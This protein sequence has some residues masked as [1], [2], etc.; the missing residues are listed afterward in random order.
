MVIFQ[1]VAVGIVATLLTLIM[2]KQSP[3]FGLYISLATGVIIFFMIIGQLE[4]VIQVMESLADKV[5]LNLS[6]MKIVFKIIGI[7][8]I[9][10]FGAQLCKDAGQGALAMKLEFSGKLLMLV[11]S[12]PILTTLINLIGDM[13]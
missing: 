2:K 6:Y 4:D 5:K 3:E 12:L 9:S 8:Y 13:L 10:E 11:V 7:A 1:I